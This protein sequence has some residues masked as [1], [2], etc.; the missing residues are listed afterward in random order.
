MSNPLNVAC[1][2]CGEPLGKPCSSVGVTHGKRRRLAASAT[3]LP[4][5][6]M[7]RLIDRMHDAGVVS[8]EAYGRMLASPASTDPNHQI[9]HLRALLS[10]AISHVENLSGS[11]SPPHGWLLK[12][13][14]ARL[15]AQYP[16]P[17]HVDVDWTVEV[18]TEKGDCVMKC[19][20]DE[21]VNALITLAEQV[22]KE[23]GT[24]SGD[25]PI[26]ALRALFREACDIGQR[27]TRAL[28]AIMPNA[29]RVVADD[30]RL[31][32]IAKEGGVV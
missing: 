25:E 8:A 20:D 5:D 29:D 22:A 11:T 32:K 26:A 4:D 9:D 28:R 19:M 17:W 18:L 12:R 23:D 14:V 13:L 31:A 3:K 16:L 30:E 24:L 7:I 21:Q 27:Y 2:T 10:I 1:P 15:V 6:A